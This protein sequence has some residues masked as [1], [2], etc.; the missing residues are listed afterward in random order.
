MREEYDVDI[1]VHEWWAEVCDN[2]IVIEW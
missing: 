1:P 2:S